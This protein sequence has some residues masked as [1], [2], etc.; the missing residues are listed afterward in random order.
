MIS[1]EEIRKI[2]K[3]LAFYL[4]RWSNDPLSY[5]IECLRM[6][7]TH[8][9]AQVLMAY[10]N[11]K[12]VAVRSGHGTRKSMVAS[13]LVH[14]YMDTHKEE[15]VACRVPITGASSDQLIDI[16][17]SEI[18][19]INKKKWDFLGNKYEIQSERMYNKESPKE[20][21]AVLRTARRENPDALQGFHKCFFIL[22]EAS[23]VPDEIFDV[24]SGSMSD[25]ESYA[26]MTGNPTKRTGYFAKSFKK[27][28]MW[29]RLHFN[30]EDTMND[31]LYSVPYV[32]PR[33]E[34]IE[35]KRKGLQSRQWI[36]N[37]KKEYGENSNTYKIRV[38]GEFAEGK[39]DNAIEWRWVS[40]IF[41]P[42]RKNVDNR[43]RKKIMGIDV[44]RKGEDAT[45]VVIRKGTAGI[46]AK[47]W[48]GND[49]VESRLKIEQI[50]R[51]H[52][53]IDEAFIDTIGIGAGLYDELRY[54]GYP[55]RPV[56]VTHVAPNNKN[57]ECKKLRD[58]LWWESRNF[59]R[60]RITTFPEEQIWIELQEELSTPTFNYQNGAIVI[61]S[62][63]EMKNRG[64]PSPNMADAWNMTMLRD[65]NTPGKF[66]S[67][68]RSEKCKNKKQVSWKCR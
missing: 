30:S 22:D 8:Q 68:K 4:K 56:D 58:W 61:E 12:F 10:R 67:A 55:V 41:A 33:G 49:L 39:A 35:L 52:P 9:Q 5:F 64:L 44:A 36:E 65:A 38:K 62:K 15:G 37:M 63:D 3:N 20:W 51:E 42:E 34:L 48:Q 19:L 24:A 50:F 18:K 32:N 40:D 16:M 59:M 45:A 54:R 43:S 11:H 17:W 2:E 27:S 21:F 14:W 13:S 25:Q 47:K 46:Y 53:D 66:M 7:P 23:G 57:G 26:L 28:G 31:T 60:T 6:E 29:H 1:K